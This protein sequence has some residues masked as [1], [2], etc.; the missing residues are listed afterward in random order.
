MRSFALALTALAVSCALS[1][2]QERLRVQGPTPATVMLGSSA[3]V[4]LVIEGRGG[5]PKA[6]VLPK[7]QGLDLRVGGPSRQVFTSITGAGMVEQVTTTWQVQITPQ[8]EGTFTIPSFLMQT[9]TREQAVPEMQ[10]TVVR[11]LRGAEFGYL[12]VQVE[13]KRVYVH[14]PIRV[15]VEFGVDKGLRPMQDVA[16]DRSRYVDF[17]VQAPWL[18]EFEGA[19]PLEQDAPGKDN[20]PVV[21]NRTLQNSEYDSDH[22][23][24]GKTYNSFVFHRSFL[25]TRPGTFTL[26]APML[27][28]HVQLSE[29]RVGIFGERVGAQSQNYYVYGQPMTLLVLPIPEVGRPQPYFGAVGRFRIE[30]GLD[31]D[32]V[33]VGSSV[34]LTLRISGSGNFEFLRLPDL[35]G[36][37]KQG[38]HL[39]GQTEQRKRDE[40]RV[41]YD[42]T[43]LSTAVT[44]VPPIAWNYFDTTEGTEAFVEQKTP[45]LPL[46]VEAL[47]D[48]ESLLPLPDAAKTAVTP[49]VDDIFDLPS[50]DG[51]PQ[52]RADV[53]FLWA[54]VAVFGPWFLLAL[55]A[56]VSM[57]HKRR[58]ADPLRLREQR[59]CKTCYRELQGGVDPS[60]AL[61][62]YLAD[63]LGVAK[64]AIIAP[65]LAQ[66]LSASGLDPDLAQECAAALERGIAARYGGGSGLDAADVKDLVARLQKSGL[67]RS[68]LASLLLI[69]ALSLTATNE[70]T[71][72]SE[73][74]LEAY[75]RGDYEQAAAA[76]EVATSQ[77][78]DRRLWFAR[79]NCYYRLSDLPRA[80][81][82]YECARLGMP[83]DAELLQNLWLV[84]KKLELVD[85]GEPFAAALLMLRERFTAREL[86]LLCGF[87][88]AMSAL[89]LAVA[90][91]RAVAR[92][93]AA[94]FLV[95]GL[96]L[97]AELLWLSPSRPPRAI[98]LVELKLTAEPREG[99]EAVATVVRGATVTLRGGTSGEW[100]RVDAAERSGYVKTSSIAVVQ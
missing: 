16:P 33:K 62:G 98:A 74:G 77:Q 11:E 49:G 6:P 12:D 36:F 57:A 68:G 1:S 41:T 24:G 86:A 59:A 20:V 32:T 89:L 76:F 2:A 30:V 93:V 14:E 39:L 69:A 7:V 88:M 72:Q 15:R 19:E 42:L 87:A 9:G 78:D 84:R 25:P 17:E 10:I 8:R 35:S 52:T 37:E 43:P 44:E 73:A 80:L 4:D 64:A 83:R 79:G 85:A 13:P 40:V 70:A 31:K 91:R 99:L 65:E 56:L 61:C 46:R 94:L 28:Y 48:G 90:R 97:A 60:E 51:A 18:S 82:A 27:R 66:R 95:H 38:L 81:W 45:P 67:R 47:P 55:T 58:V 34:K 50:L 92:W 96:L 54:L 29:G 63:R 22:K 53:P 21:L 3:R 75:R 26:D 5:E 71:A 100:V 23:R